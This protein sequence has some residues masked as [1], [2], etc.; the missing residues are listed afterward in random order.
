MQCTAARVGSL[1]GNPLS[2][3]LALLMPG[4]PDAKVRMYV[5]Y[6]KYWTLSLMHLVVYPKVLF[7]PNFS[8]KAWV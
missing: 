1:W 5:V 2:L 6:L 4:S 8:I 7:H 3:P